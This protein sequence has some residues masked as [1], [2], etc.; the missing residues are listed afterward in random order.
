MLTP[1]ILTVKTFG[2]FAI[3]RQ[4]GKNTLTISEHDNL[5]RKLWGL[6]EYLIVFQKRGAT[7]DELIDAFWGGDFGRN[8]D[9]NLKALVFR[10][11][12]ALSALGFPI[13]KDIICCESNGYRFSDSLTFN[14]DA[15]QFETLCCQ[16]ETAK[17]PSLQLEKAR[18][19]LCLYDGDFLAKSIEFAWAATL[20]VYYHSKYLK[21]CK[22]TIDLLAK[23][24]RHEEIITLCKRALKIEPYDEI[25]HRALIEA[26]TETGAMQAAMRHYTYVVDFFITEL[27]VSPSRELTALYHKITASVSPKEQ[28]L[29]NFRESLTERVEELTPFLCGY[30]AFTEICRLEARAIS[31][32]QESSQLIMLVISRQNGGT[33]S[34]GQIN[35][36]MEYL[37]KAIMAT[38]RSSD[39]F[40]RFSSVKF[41]LL[42]PN[43]SSENGHKAVNRILNSFSTKHPRV[44]YVISHTLLPVLPNE[45]CGSAVS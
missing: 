9:N 5:S 33:I 8:P 18:A 23:A 31:R 34:S 36:G 10:S 7:R 21:L 38:L 26:F 37:R 29:H 24:R 2:G 6:L 45:P 27:S 41:L 39:V 15:E 25:L 16:A 32:S 44:S 13:G 11:R 30:A 28:D 35:S 1:A 42:L 20:N 43:T 40:C 22:S 17:Y 3:S 14:I 19:A 4:I 12:N